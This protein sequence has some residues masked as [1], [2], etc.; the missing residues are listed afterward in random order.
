MVTVTRHTK[1]LQLRR[2][3][4][5]DVYKVRTCQLFHFFLVGKKIVKSKNGKEVE[6]PTS[7]FSF[8]ATESQS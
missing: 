2:K 1:R 4:G 8:L 7:I 5:L 6:V 3:F